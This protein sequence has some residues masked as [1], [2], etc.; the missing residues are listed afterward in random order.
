MGPNI[1]IG[2]L[3]GPELCELANGPVIAS[4]FGLLSDDGPYSTVLQKVNL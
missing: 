2:R 3:R 4:G 1:G